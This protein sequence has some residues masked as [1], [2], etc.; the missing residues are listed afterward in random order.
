MSVAG[1]AAHGRVPALVLM[2]T[3]HSDPL[4]VR[5]TTAFLEAYRPELV[6][7]ELSPFALRYRKEHTPSLLKT[8]RANLRTAAGRLGIHFK[9]AIRHNR[10][11]AIIRQISLPFEYRA[12]ASYARKTGVPVIPIDKSEFS[13][14]WIETWPEMLSAANLEMLLRCEDRIE[15]V[16][17]QYALAARKLSASSPE[18]LFAA[19]PEAALWGDRE[20]HLACS[21]TAELEKMRP[22]RAVYLGGWRHLLHAEK[23]MSLRDMLDVPSTACL[24]LD[25]Y[26]L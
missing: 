23:A 18:P 24:L 2:G 14:Q 22:G 16:A 12:S 10:I 21:V 20:K 13:R 8:L 1:D 9:Q 11:V 5:R 17:G 26:R 6:L 19:E 25:R 7:L 15:S 3:V 4:G